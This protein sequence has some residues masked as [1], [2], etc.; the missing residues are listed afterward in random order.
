MTRSGTWKVLKRLEQEKY[1][2]MKPTGKETSLVVPKLNFKNDLL[3]K[4]LDLALSREAM[5]YER[6]I[7]NF[8][9]VKEHVSFFILHGSIL[10]SYAKSN[11]I[12]VIGVISDRKRFKKLHESLDKIQIS[13]AKHIHSIN[14]TQSELREELLKPNKVFIEAVKK[15]VVLF[16]QEEFIKFIKKLHTASK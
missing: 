3:D 12:D 13:Q 8:K 4:Y 10:K 16:G 7:F 5:N 1:I 11:D 6:W 14:F 2:I 9:D 15:G